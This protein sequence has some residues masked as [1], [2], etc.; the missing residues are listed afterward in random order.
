MNMA[1][2]GMF[3]QAQNKLMFVKSIIDIKLN[4]R[5]LD[6]SYSSFEFNCAM[7]TTLVLKSSVAVCKAKKK[8]KKSKKKN[9]K[10][11][12]FDPYPVIY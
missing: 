8:I 11:Q 3:I 5:L 4:L 7:T 12:Y 10:N 1:H 6:S 2:L 9:K